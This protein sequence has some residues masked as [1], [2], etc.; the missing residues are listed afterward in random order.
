MARNT[1]LVVNGG[2]TFDVDRHY[3]AKVVGNAWGHEECTKNEMAVDGGG[4]GEGDV[5][6]FEQ[7]WGQVRHAVHLGIQHDQRH[8]AKVG[9]VSGHS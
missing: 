2:D 3:W 1:E 8:E 9:R 4:G 5:N 6:N 7:S